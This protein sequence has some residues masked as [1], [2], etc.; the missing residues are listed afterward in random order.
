[1]L[2]ISPQRKRFDKTMLVPISFEQADAVVRSD[3]GREKLVAKGS[4]HV[5]NGQVESNVFTFV[6][7]LHSHKNMKAQ[8][9]SD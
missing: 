1:M 4:A 5:D 7:V 3:Q 2:H 9:L 8:S 6:R